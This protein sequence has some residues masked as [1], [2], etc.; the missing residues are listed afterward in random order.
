MT[1]FRINGPQ[2][3]A[4]ETDFDEALAQQLKSIFSH[5]EARKELQT[6]DLPDLQVDFFINSANG[7]AVVVETKYLQPNRKIDYFVFP[8]FAALNDAIQNLPNQASTPIVAVVTNADIPDSVQEVFA[9]TGIPFITLGFTVDET[10][11]RLQEAFQKLGIALPELVFNQPAR[12]FFQQATRSQSRRE[13]FTETV[14]NYL[15]RVSLN[16]LFLSGTV[17]LVGLG[18]I[19]LLV[20][21]ELWLLEALALVFFLSAGALV[22]SRDRKKEERFI[23]PKVII[24]S[25]ERNLTVQKDQWLMERHLLLKARGKVERYLFNVE[26]TGS[27]K[28]V[29]I[30]CVEGGAKTVQKD[31][32]DSKAMNW[33][34]WGLEFDK[35]LKRGEEREIVL[36]YIL[37]DPEHTAAPFHKIAFTNVWQCR[38]FTCRLLLAEGMKPRA[39]YLVKEATKPNFEREKAEI[40]P[41][42]QS[43]TYVV[44][45]RPAPLSKFSLEWDLK[46]G[47]GKKRR[48]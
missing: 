38:E 48:H 19:N 16:L 7:Q 30:S 6:E 2:V 32:I 17:V 41:E 36:E 46:N 39:V 45:E 43:H 42:P 23:N 29:Q 33:H 44:H 47:N 4:R 24:K 31:F 13:E 8:P 27:S 22:Y 1:M 9:E 37:P 12:T 25:E 11:Q 28:N 26:W 20:H 10:K 21:N 5:V 35:P 15:D 40:L 18:V 34:S 14:S 3:R